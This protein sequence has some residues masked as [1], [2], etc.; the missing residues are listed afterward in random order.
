VGEPVAERWVPNQPDRRR[1]KFGWGLTEQDVRAVLDAQSAD[2][3]SGGHD[4]DTPSE[5]LEDLDGGSTAVSE[6][7]DDGRGALVERG[8]VFDPS[9]HPDAREHPEVADRLFLRSHKV[10]VDGS[11]EHPGHL[12]ND[13]GRQ[14]LCRLDVGRVAQVADE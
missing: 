1:A 2:A 13:L 9:A 5:R 11:P 3:D 14:G 4:R 12:R 6:R 7:H 10:G 8:Q